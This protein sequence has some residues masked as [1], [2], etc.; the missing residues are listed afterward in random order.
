MVYTKLSRPRSVSIAVSI[1]GAA[2][3]GALAAVMTFTIQIPYPV[4]GFE[5][6]RFDAAELIDATA[7]LVFG[8]LVGF[9]TALIHWGVLNFLPTALPIYGPLLKFAA[10]TSMLLGMWLGC[11]TYSRLLKGRGGKRVGYWLTGTTGLVTRVLVMTPINYLVLVF[12]FNAP[13]SPEV[14]N[15]YLI[16]IGV[17][18]A[19]HALISTVIPLVLVEGVSRLAPNLRDR[20]WSSAISLP[21]TLRE[22]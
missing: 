6:L 20:M 12:V 15:P 1:A 2:V 11:A 8:P 18:N 16:G 22:A 10:V 21:S 4:P 13:A 3:F 19:I 17:F 7:L 14:V 5:F 9:L